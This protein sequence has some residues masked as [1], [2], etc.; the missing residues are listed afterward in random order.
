MNEQNGGVTLSGDVV[1][2]PRAAGLLLFCVVVFFFLINDVLSLINGGGLFSIVWA[3]S[4]AGKGAAFVDVDGA[5]LRTLFILTCGTII[6]AASAVIRI[7][8]GSRIAWVLIMVAI[9]GGGFALDGMFGGAVI[10]HILASH[11]YSRCENGDFQTGNG[12]GRVWHTHYVLKRSGCPAKARQ[13]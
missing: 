9:V 1:L 3:L 12:K 10:R 11:G 6:A 4:A 5:G 2:T 13:P 7:R 8:L